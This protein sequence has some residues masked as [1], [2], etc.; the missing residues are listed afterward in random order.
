VADVDA[1]LVAALLRAD[2]DGAERLVAQYGDRAYRLSLQITGRAQ[3]AE[4]IV[5][6]A[7]RTAIATIHTFTD[8]STLES[9]IVRSVASMAYWTLRRREQGENEISIADVAPVLDVDGHWKPMGD[10]SNQIDGNVLKGDL[11]GLMSE[12]LDGIRIPVNIRGATFDDAAAICAIYNQGIDDRIA[13]L[14]T[15]RRTPE[16]RRA[17]LA[18]RAPRHPVFVAE[19][20]GD[21]V[22]GWASLNAFNP[23]PA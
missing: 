20:D 6:E 7:L 8:A 12:A 4:A 3:D 23:R 9:W 1:E 18:A 2:A 15:E 17:W 16:E 11:D 13:T 22:I 10:W 19:T 5:E 21:G 14:E